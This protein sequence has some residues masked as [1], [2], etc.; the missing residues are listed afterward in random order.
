LTLDFAE[1]L[2]WEVDFYKDVREGDRFKL[3]VEKLYKGNEFVR[4]GVIHAVEYQGEG[5]RVRGIRYQDGY[6]DENGLSLRKVF[7]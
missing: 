7:L 5:K 1:I 4:Y 3:V 2:A 6:Y